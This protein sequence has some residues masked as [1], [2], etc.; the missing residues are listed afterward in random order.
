MRMNGFKAFVF[1]DAGDLQFGG[2]CQSIVG[3]RT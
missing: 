2:H 3:I 1:F